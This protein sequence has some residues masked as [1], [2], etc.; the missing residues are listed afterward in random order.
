MSDLNIESLQGDRKILDILR[1]FGAKVEIGDLVT[2]E[3]NYRKNIEVDLKDVPDLLPIL[4]ILAT[5]ADGGVSKF[6]NGER[7]RLKKERQ[8]EFNC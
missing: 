1:D 8:I 4:A 6:Y 5:S 7:L 3:P 2:I